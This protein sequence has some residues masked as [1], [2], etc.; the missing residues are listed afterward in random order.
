[1]A[2]G[3]RARHVADLGLSGTYAGGLALRKELVES[4]AAK[5]S[6]G[7][8]ESA[9]MLAPP[10]EEPYLTRDGSQE[11]APPWQG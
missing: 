10:L 1:M 11:N 2:T 4:N 6:A 7:I 3:F 5:S 9:I 8:H